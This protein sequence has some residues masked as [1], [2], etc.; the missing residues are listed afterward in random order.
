MGIPIISLLFTMSR[1][2]LLSFVSKANFQDAFSDEV[3]SDLHPIRGIKHHIDFILGAALPNK[4]T[5]RSN[6]NETK[7]I[8]KQVSDLLFKGCP[9]PI[10]LVPKKDGTW[11]MCVDWQAINKIIVKYRHHIPRLDDMLDK[12][13]GSCYF[14]KIDLKSGY[15]QIRIREGDEWKTAFKTK[16]ELYGWLVIP[17]GLTNVPSTLM[18]LMNHE[19]HSFLGKFVVV[20]FYDILI[21]NKSLKEYLEHLRSVLHMLRKE[22][23]YANFDK[24]SFCT[25]Q[26]IFLGFV[27]SSKGVK[28]DEKKDF[29]TPVTPLIEIMKK[30]VRF[31][32]E[33]EQERTFNS[34][35]EKLTNAPLLVLPNFTKSFEIESDASGMD[36]GAVLMQEGHPIAY[37]SEKLS[38]A[39]LNYPTYDK[40]LY[41]LVRSL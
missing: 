12:L 17:F 30:S 11:G 14:S 36:I 25:E 7:E 3:P 33:E 41:A 10:L 18:L 20:Y 15:H 6:P 26:V 40:E 31:K 34:L 8:Q 27:N 2:L 35:K 5:Y 38:G 9:I 39:T 37:F 23:L 4:L 24:C 22:K 19:L 13:H 1:K 21:Y 16:Y 32:W 28:V 29:S